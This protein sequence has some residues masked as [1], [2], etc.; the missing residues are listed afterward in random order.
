VADEMIVH[1]VIGCGGTGDGSLIDEAGLVIEGVW[2]DYEDAYR[3]SSVGDQEVHSFTVAGS[4][5]GDTREI[6]WQEVPGVG[7]DRD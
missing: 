5:E 3:A 2:S 7:G 1:V 4:L 6:P